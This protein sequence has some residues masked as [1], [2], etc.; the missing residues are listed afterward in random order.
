MPKQKIKNDKYKKSRGGKS[1]I[2]VISCARCSNSILEYQKDG[3]PGTLKR[4]YLDRIHLP[5]RLVGLE[6][7]A[8]S[9]IPNLRCDNCDNVLAVPYL[10]KREKRTAYRINKG[11]ILKTI[12]SI[13]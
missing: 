12:K 9:E 4:M 8:I 7:L 3:P 13:S 10:Y 1:R 11:T 6:K 2:L 5:K